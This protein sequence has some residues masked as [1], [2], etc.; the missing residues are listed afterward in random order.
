MNLSRFTIGT[1]D[2]FGRQGQ[3]QLRALH[4]A[5]EAG[6][7]V[8]PVWNKSNREHTLIGT[9]PADTRREADD[10]VHALGWTY[11]YHVDADHINLSNVDRFIPAS[12][13]FTLDVADAIGKTDAPDTVEAFVQ[14]ITPR[15][16]PIQLPAQGEVTFSSDEAR[17]AAEVFLFAAREAG[18][19]YRHLVEAKGAGNF[20]TEVSMDETVRPQSPAELYFILA[21]LAREGVPVRTVAPKFTGSFHKGVDYIGDI[22]K[23]AAE[24]EADLAV[25]RAAI[26][27]FG[28]PE[29]LKLSVHSGSDKFSLYPVMN[30]LVQQYGAGL[31][32]K[33]AGTTW[34]EEVIGLA[35]AG[36]EGLEIAKSISTEALARYD[37]LSGPYATVIHIERERL[38]GAGT[39]SNWTSAQFVEAL[40]HEPQCP[41]FQPDFR[42]LVHIAFKIAAGMGQRYLNA[43]DQHQTIIAK[44]VTHNLWHR[45]LKPLYAGAA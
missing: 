37:E 3:A 31:H 20:V 41:Q 6:I 4:L 12:D 13:F 21:M 16:R 35:E 32:L 18:R 9:D 30:R 8:S 36:G 39:I 29:D 1:G 7:P 5:R 26:G 42:Q 10:A 11:G 23:F 14:W 2:R 38:P 25:I 43:L 45:H 22:S 33:T 40:R 19:L 44:N 17:A 24:F 27:D 15:L 34:L 28:L